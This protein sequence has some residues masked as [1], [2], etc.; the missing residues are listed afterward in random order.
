MKR[1]E[2]PAKNPGM[3]AETMDFS[4]HRVALFLF[5]LMVM[6]DQVWSLPEPFDLKF[7]SDEAGDQWVEKNDDTCPRFDLNGPLHYDNVTIESFEACEDY[8]VRL[9][10][11]GG[12]VSSLI[13][14]AEMDGDTLDTVLD[15]M[16]LT[17]AYYE[18]SGYNQDYICEWYLEYDTGSDEYYPTVTDYADYYVYDPFQFEK[19]YEWDSIS[20]LRKNVDIYFDDQMTM[21]LTGADTKYV[22]LVGNLFVRN[23]SSQQDRDIIN[24]RIGNDFS[25]DFGFVVTFYKARKYN[26]MIGHSNSLQFIVACDDKNTSEITDNKCYSMTQYQ[27]LDYDED[28]SGELEASFNLDEGLKPTKCFFLI[29]AQQLPRK[30]STRVRK[31][32][33]FSHKKA[34]SFYHKCRSSK[35]ISSR[36]KC[37]ALSTRK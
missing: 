22:N 20:F 11:A 7:G 32:G 23:I 21:I 37:L 14:L 30:I 3:Y 6:I 1:F 28:Y 10:Q 34:L 16:C 4:V 33:L 26:H 31:L 2:S 29:K 27:Q 24:A 18:T 8:E 17:S 15:R 19:A 5:I 13:Y 25:V 35:Y 36:Q 9:I 12:V